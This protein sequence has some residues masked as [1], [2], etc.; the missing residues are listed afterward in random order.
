MRK[1]IMKKI[2]QPNNPADSCR[3]HVQMPSKS[4]AAIITEHIH[5][6]V[7]V[8]VGRQQQEHPLKTL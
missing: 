3:E 5:G 1:E 7:C 6:T 2:R 8:R 4:L